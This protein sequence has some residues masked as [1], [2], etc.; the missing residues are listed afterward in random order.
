MTSQ[1]RKKAVQDKSSGVSPKTNEYPS[2]PSRA[3]PWSTSDSSGKK[4]ENGFLLKKE[5][6]SQKMSGKPSKNSSKT[7]IL[8]WKRPKN[9]FAHDLMIFI[10]RLS[11]AQRY[12]K[13]FK[14][15]NL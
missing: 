2:V 8:L 14:E 11:F 12:P 15:S 3:K 9:D 5:S 1:S 4:M 7:L 6:L 13:I 10:V